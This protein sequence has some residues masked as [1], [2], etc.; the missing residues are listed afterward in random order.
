MSSENQW[1]VEQ[2]QNFKH[3]M[4]C[5]K[6]YK[7]ELTFVGNQVEHQ[8]GLLFIR[9]LHLKDTNLTTLL[10]WKV[11]FP[12]LCHLKCVISFPFGNCLDI[13]RMFYY[14]L[15]LKNMIVLQTHTVILAFWMPSTQTAVK[16][17]NEYSIICRRRKIEN[18]HIDTFLE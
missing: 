1:K 5:G 10:H 6:M 17:N 18:M 4:C 15:H 8:N 2:P 7:I 12:I 13:S 14:I 9:R 11:I 16:T 3:I